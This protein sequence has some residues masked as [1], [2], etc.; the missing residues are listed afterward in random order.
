MKQNRWL[1]PEGIGELLPADAAALETLRRELTDLYWSWGYELIV[2]PF[3]E[4]LDSLLTGTGH[5]LDIQ[6]FKL[7]DQLNGKSM[8][9]RS[10]MTPQVARIDAH[11]LA[12]TG[13]TRL[14]YMGTTLLTRPDGFSGNRSP[15]QLGAEIYGHAGAQSDVEVISLMLSTLRHCVGNTIYLDLG[16]VGIFRGLAK[17]AGLSDEQE[18]RLFN[19]MQ[20]KSVPEIKAFINEINLAEGL[21]ENFTSLVQLSGQKDVLQQAKTCFAETCAEITD[22]LD[23]LIQISIL[24]QQIEPSVQIHFDLSELRGYS[25]HTGVVFA[26]YIDDHGQ[27]LARGGRYD[28]IGQCFGRS[29]PATGFSTDLKLLTVL[30]QQQSTQQ[31]IK[32]IY[33]PDTSDSSV[34]EKINQLRGAGEIVACALSDSIPESQTLQFDRILVFDNGDWIVREYKHG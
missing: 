23:E 22:A 5:E 27:E 8:G 2:P 11:R 31:I 6:T 24:L 17:H 32:A 28:D 19:M 3:I 20:R 25:Y 29:R 4:Y 21:G 1:L 16:H 30:R 15:L 34:W 14:F 13:V 26:A 7:I 12:A 9:V 33:V 10:D 18:I